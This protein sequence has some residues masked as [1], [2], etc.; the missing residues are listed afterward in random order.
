MSNLFIFEFLCKLHCYVMHLRIYLSCRSRPVRVRRYCTQIS[1]VVWS[2]WQCSTMISVICLIWYLFIG[3]GLFLGIFDQ[4]LNSSGM[5]ELRMSPSR[6]TVR[7]NRVNKDIFDIA[8]SCLIIKWL[9]ILEFM[10]VVDY[11]IGSRICL[12]VCKVSEWL[13][14]CIPTDKRKIVNMSRRN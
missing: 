8:V 3:L 11:C 4:I 6:S 2:V 7:L 1:P 12:P 14:I 13:V 10:S 5:P 9:F